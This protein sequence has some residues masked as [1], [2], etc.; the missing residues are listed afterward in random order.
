MG[1]IRNHSVGD[2][3]S[4]LIMFIEIINFALNSLLLKYGRFKPT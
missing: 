1:E 3:K 4:I 2:K